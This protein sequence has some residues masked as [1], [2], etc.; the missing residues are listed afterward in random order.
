MTRQKP[1]T[2]DA[3]LKVDLAKENTKNINRKKE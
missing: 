1:R 2:E 3:E